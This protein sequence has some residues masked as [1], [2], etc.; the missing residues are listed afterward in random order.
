MSQCQRL[1]GIDTSLRAEDVDV[2]IRLKPRRPH[3]MQFL[4]S[5][6]H[7]NMWALFASGLTAKLDLELRNR[8]STFA[9]DACVFAQ[10]K[11]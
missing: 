6:D 9:D 8:Q 5:G 4:F 10:E 7:G 3:T 2:R 11:A 1:S